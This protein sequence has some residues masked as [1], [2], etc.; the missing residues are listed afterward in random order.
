MIRSLLKTMDDSDETFCYQSQF[1]TNFLIHVLIH[2]TISL[3]WPSN[4][5][6]PIPFY[7]REKQR[8]Y[9]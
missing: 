2:T 3:S 1:I 8:A 7:L 6:I 9:K 5:F 4:L